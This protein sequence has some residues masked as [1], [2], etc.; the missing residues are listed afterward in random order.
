MPRMKTRTLKHKMRKNKSRQKSTRKK[1]NTKRRK[2]GVGFWGS[3]PAPVDPNAPP[4]KKK[5]DGFS[6]T[7]HFADYAKG[8]LKAS[9][10]AMNMPLTL[11]TMNYK[12]NALMVKNN[13]NY[14]F[15]NGY[16]AKDYSIDKVSGEASNEGRGELKPNAVRGKITG[17]Q[18]GIYTTA[19]ES[20]TYD[21]MKKKNEE[22]KLKK[23]NAPV[24]AATPVKTSTGAIAQ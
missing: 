19:M 12:L 8:S 23:A 16:T 17:A 18:S 1:T 3:T 22:A 4:P 11:A 24:K 2:G 15:S 9:R 6:S 13:V 14:K 21:K 5:S 10:S 7:S 20:D